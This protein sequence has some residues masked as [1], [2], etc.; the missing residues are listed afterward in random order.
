MH[1]RSTPVLIV[2][3]G[4]GGLSTAVFLGL[5]GVP[6]LVV[7]RH[8]G[9][10]QEPKARGQMP[11]TMEALRAAGLAEGFRAAAPPGRPEMTIVIAT[12]VTG[13]VLHSFT[14]ALPDFG[15]FSPAPTGLVSQE[16]AE[17]LLAARARELGAEIRFS[18]RMESFT[19]DEDGITAVLRDLATDETYEVRAP[20][21]VGADGHRGGVRE[22]IGIGAHGRGV[23]EESTSLLFEAS[24]DPVL[25]GAAVQMHYLQNPE[26][27]G[28]SGMF[29]S[30]DTPGRFVAVVQDVR[31]DDHA[32]E[33]IRLITGVPDLAVKLIGRTTWSTACR[34]ADRFSGAD[35]RVHL[36]GDAAHLMP[37]TGGQGGNTAVMDGFHLAWKLA[38]TVR[39][40]AGPGLLA[41]HDAERRPF[42]EF[43]VEQQYANLV[44]R[45]APHLA[46]DTVAER[47]DPARLLFGYR[48]PAGAF[49]D[50]PE[51]GPGAADAPLFEDPAAPS[52]RPGTR[53]PHVALADGTSTRDLYGRDFV[54]L[55]GSPTWRSA[56]LA[57][58]ERLQMPVAV[59]DLDGPWAPAHGVTPSGAVLVRPDGIIAW[60][61]AATG[62]PRDVERALRTVLDR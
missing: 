26:L 55:T 1:S 4:L 51:P 33:V 15:R 36:V 32:C 58:A 28:G 5:H 19:V 60:R 29:V 17:P 3:A 13:R 12:S 40:Q 37:P 35:G 43:L 45:A 61:A 21:L 14:E 62:D 18:T 7:E 46:D 23:L 11:A 30:T 6:A 42:A 9:T 53:A 34:I 20:Y 39:G 31:D 8:P 16:R 47:L 48:C 2:G 10:S 22:A 54:L 50:E 38:A 52:G 56:A 49:T 44:H 41:S 25:D 24:L 59:P 57:A 27:P